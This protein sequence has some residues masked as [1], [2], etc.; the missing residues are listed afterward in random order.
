MLKFFRRKKR[1]T[2]STYP[3]KHANDEYIPDAYRSISKSMN[4]SRNE[5][6]TQILDNH[7][8]GINL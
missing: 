5:K 4:Q 8:S 6:P 2:K 1:E 3:P 7:Q